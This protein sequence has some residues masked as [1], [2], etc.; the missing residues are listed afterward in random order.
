MEK[1]SLVSTILDKERNIRFNI[2]AYRKL[3]RAEMIET[4]S[5]FYSQ[6]KQP[7]KLKRGSTITIVTIIGYDT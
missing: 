2:L 4:V 3:T 6:K 1:P 7:K 5:H